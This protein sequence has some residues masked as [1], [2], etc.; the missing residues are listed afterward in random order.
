MIEIILAKILLIDDHQLFNDGIRVLLSTQPDLVVCGQVFEEKDILFAVQKHT[1]ELVLLDLNIQGRSG[2]EIGMQLMSSQPNLKVVI[3]TMYNQPKLFEEALKAGF[4]GYMLKD[5]T[6]AELLEGI[7]AVIAGRKYYDPRLVKQLSPSISPFKDDFALR[8]NLTFRELEMIRLVR[9][10]LTS[11][12]IADKLNL[13]LFTVKTHRRNIYYKLGI[14]N[15]A[16]LIE[17][18][19]RNGL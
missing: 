8:A 11:E 9:E 10:G 17:F 5:S 15:V 19:S 2:L 7:R 3:L 1:P 18:A 4:H 14:G 12:E 6:T 16:E 13:S